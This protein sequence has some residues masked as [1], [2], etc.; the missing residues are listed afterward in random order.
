MKIIVIQFIIV[1][2]NYYIANTE[3]IKRIYVVT[4]LFNLSNLIMYLFN[5]DKTTTILYIIITLRSLVYIYRDKLK[6][7]LIPIIAILVQ[8]IV[9]FTTID[10]AWQLIPIVIPCYVCYY[11]WFNKTTQQLRLSNAFCN[12]MWFVYNMKTGLYIVAVSRLITTVNNIMAYRK[13]KESIDAIEND[14]KMKMQSKT[15]AK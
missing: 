10:N 1:L 8:L 9:G 14:C 5:K 15:I 7:V 13:N 4:F 6:T 11:M 2:I 3:N 12:F